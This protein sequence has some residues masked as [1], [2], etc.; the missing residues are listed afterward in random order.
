MRFTWRALVLAPIF[1]PLTY[2]ALFAAAAGGKPLPI[3]SF[4]VLFVPA[5][6][7]SYCVTIFLFLPALLILSRFT[8]LTALLACV[9]GTAFGAIVWLPVSRVMWLSSGH[10]S[11]PPAGP[12]LES[13]SRELADPLTLSFPV[14]GLVTAAIFWALAR[15]PDADRRTEAG[16]TAARV[17]KAVVLAPPVF[18]FVF[19]AVLNVVHPAGA[20]VT[21]FV[22]IATAAI[23]F[24][25]AVTVLL[26]LPTLWL[27]SKITRLTAPIVCLA[28]TALGVAGYGLIRLEGPADGSTPAVRP[29]PFV[30]FM[31]QAWAEQMIWVF[32][33]AG[34]VTAALFWM[35][36]YGPRWHLPGETATVAR[37]DA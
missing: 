33:F 5:A 18:P 13:L 27:L 4:L 37:K 7:F 25:Y 30:A 22:M 9:T 16:S 10:D 6:V 14:G 12:W 19:A 32:P 15:H 17:W 31:P 24:S 20:A 2:C 8:R 36:A 11:G 26:F 34:F 28:G 1:V 29:D 35:L 21:V 23:V 3:G